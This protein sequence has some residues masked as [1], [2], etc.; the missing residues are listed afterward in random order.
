MN[1]YKQ[2]KIQEIR[3]KLELKYGYNVT[4]VMQLTSEICIWTFQLNQW[5]GYYQSRQQQQEAHLRVSVVLLGWHCDPQCHNLFKGS[6]CDHLF[7]RH[8]R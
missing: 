5:Q 1:E 2:N 3:G 4:M 7:L 8:K 6:Q